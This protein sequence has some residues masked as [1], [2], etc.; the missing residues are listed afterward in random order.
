MTLINVFKENVLII[1]IE[2]LSLRDRR[3]KERKQE[4]LRL[5]NSLIHYILFLNLLI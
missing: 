2:P 4:K 1:S 3:W 5:E